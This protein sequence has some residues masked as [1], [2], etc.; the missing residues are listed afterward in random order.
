MKDRRGWK[1]LVLVAVAFLALQITWYGVNVL[2][3][4]AKSMHTYIQ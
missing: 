2:P 4:A 1:A 3:S